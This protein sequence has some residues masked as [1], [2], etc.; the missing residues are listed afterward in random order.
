MFS[1]LSPIPMFFH[2]LSL[3]GSL[4][5][6]SMSFWL[7]TPLLITCWFLSSLKHSVHIGVSF[8]ILVFCL[9]DCSFKI[10]VYTAYDL[11]SA[12]LLHISCVLL[13]TNQEQIPLIMGLFPQLFYT[14]YVL[15]FKVIKYKFQ[16][17]WFFT[18][19]FAAH[20]LGVKAIREKFQCFGLFLYNSFIYLLG[21]T[22]ISN[23]F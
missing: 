4:I 20:L 7:C 1:F 19:C 11:S 12:A 22:V 23:K 16:W 17:V 21:F 8:P 9:K 3:T 2:R 10:W 5:V 18:Y 13:Y 14:S 15:N 6:F